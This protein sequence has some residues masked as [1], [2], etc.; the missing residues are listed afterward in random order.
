MATRPRTPPRQRFAGSER[1][2][3]LNTAFAELPAES[4]LR[5]GHMQKALYRLGPATTAIFAFE[6]GGG[7]DQ[8]TVAGEAIIHVIRGR[9]Q[10]RTDE[11]S[12]ELTRDQMVLLDPGIP[13]DLH[14]LEP[15]RLLLTVVLK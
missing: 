8:Y 10:V 15:T 3:D 11:G 6:A 5:Q 13:H 2:F 1:L 4:V 14:A 9:L 7:L 12:Y